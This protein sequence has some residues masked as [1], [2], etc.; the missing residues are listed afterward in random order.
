MRLEG[1]IYGGDS[2]HG[3]RRLAADPAPLLSE[4]GGG[5]QGIIWKK[6]DYLLL[7]LT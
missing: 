7:N 1:V 2:L 5:E 6:W 4:A 3:M